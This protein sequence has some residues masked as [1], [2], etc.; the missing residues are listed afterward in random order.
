MDVLKRL[1]LELLD[2]E[3][4]EAS[5]TLAADINEILCGLHL[6]GGDWKKFGNA[7]EAK[8]GL[9]ARKKQVDKAT[10]ADQDGR[11]RAMAEKVLEWAGANGYGGKVQ[12]VWWTAR[13]GTLSAAV[14][15][16]VD[17][18]KNPTDILIKFTKGGFLGVSAK[19]TKG[20][21]DIG[22]KNP[23]LGTLA[24]TLGVDFGSLIKNVEEK[25]ITKY[26]LPAGIK[27]RKAFIRGN[28]KIQQK[29]IE[30][31]AQMLAILRDALL[32]K[33][34]TMPQPELKKHILTAW[35]DAES[36]D[37]YYIKVTG[38][39]AGGTYT[40]DVFDPVKNDKFEL[41]KNGKIEAVAVGSDSV[42]LMAD[43]HRLL[44]A[45]FKFESEKLASSIKL[46]GDPWTDK[47]VAEHP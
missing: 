36:V 31:G 28:P 14:G 19:S 5:N 40:A 15:H 16:P 47:K 38:R 25:I 17:S 34:Q 29:T 24:K 43:G 32:K 12:T 11:A 3:L 13:P 37:P 33:Y 42:G 46:S 30:A 35:L 41:I 4:Q 1:V 2:V 22:F 39:G 26:K 23:G 27:V 20:A 7:K 8:A 44:K 18:R 6:V 45:R 9:D 21:G 10:Y